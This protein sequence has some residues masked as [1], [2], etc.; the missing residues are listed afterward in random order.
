MRLHRTGLSLRVQN[1][2]VVEL[3]QRAPKR[4]LAAEARMALSGASLTGNLG[5]EL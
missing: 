3:T 1:L 4:H 2:A 5:M